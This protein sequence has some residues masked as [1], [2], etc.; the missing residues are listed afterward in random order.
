[1][2]PLALARL[3]ARGLFA[4]LEESELA[5]VDTAVLDAPGTAES[6]VATEA[7]APAEAA[8]EEVLTETDGAI[9]PTDSGDEAT[10]QD[11][12]DDA[13]PSN[14]KDALA[15]AEKAGRAKEAESVR[16]RL[17]NERQKAEEE[18]L[19]RQW[20]ERQ[21][22]ASREGQGRIW[23]ALSAA[24]RQALDQGL[25][26]DRQQ[27]QQ[28]FFQMVQGP[29]GALYA[30]LQAR[31]INDVDN[32]W[33][34][35]IQRRFSGAKLDGEASSAYA[36]AFA[37]GDMGKMLDSLMQLAEEAVTQ[38]LTPKLRAEVEAEMAKTSGKPG[39]KAVPKAGPTA[40]LANSRAVPGMKFN[41]K[42]EADAAMMNGQWT[43]KNRA[44][45]D[46]MTQGL[47]Y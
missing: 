33:G 15:A 44:D 19:I 18:V 7:F 42:R 28:R 9:E 47:P 41:T 14:W 29:I 11:G 21:S 34:A 16:Q 35:V 24:V 8:A 46:R 13:P 3:R 17:D 26:L 20:Q 5:D 6:P 37:A 23:G 22:L 36:R 27:D 4:F 10:E 38:R 40:G 25:D 2:W 39:A 43:P 32:A 30:G 12:N 1:M 45:Y 31:S